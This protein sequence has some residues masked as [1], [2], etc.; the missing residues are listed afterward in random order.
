[1]SHPKAFLERFIRAVRK[2]VADPQ[3]SGR[4]TTEDLLEDLHSADRDI[5]DELLRSI[6]QESLLGYAEATVTFQNAV[7]YY[8]FPEGFRQFVQLERRVDGYAVDIIRSKQYYSQ[9]RGVDV[10]SSTR[11][12]R[13]FP[14]PSLSSDQDWV[15]CYLRS[16]GIHHYA[17]TTS[18]GSKN[19][20]SGTPV[21]G[22]LVLIPDYYNGM[23]IRIFAADNKAVPQTNTVTS[24]TVSEGKGTFHLQRE[25]S[26]IP[27]GEVW[28]E[29]VP[30][31]PQEYEEI[32]SLELALKILERRGKVERL[33]SLVSRRK[34][35][36]SACKQFVIA[37]VSDRAPSKTLPLRPEDLVPS[38]EVPY[39]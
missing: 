10:L 15:L 28:Y 8:P 26:P 23:E 11:G 19:L 38:G 29:T 25:W 2:E 32:Y 17:Q 22:D 16:A 14:A 5:F 18:V 30:N 31:V 3:S 37:N 33:P 27:T 6:G 34:K 36:W 24:F 4:L 7:S 39:G 1:M 13:M 20:V 21:L 9:R 12:F 35:K